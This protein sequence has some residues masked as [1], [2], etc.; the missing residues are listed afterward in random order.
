MNSEELYLQYA[1]QSFSNDINSHADTGHDDTHMDG[2][3]DGAPDEGHV[4]I[5]SDDSW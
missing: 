4:D 2:H 5:H 3:S 1:E